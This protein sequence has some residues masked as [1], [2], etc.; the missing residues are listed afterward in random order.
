MPDWVRVLLAL[1][2]RVAGLVGLKTA[3]SKQQVE[4]EIINFNG[5]P[6]EK[7]ALFQVLA[8]NPQEI[9]TGQDDKH[10]NFRLS[11]RLENLSP[12][13]YRLWLI[14]TVVQH[15]QVGRW[16]M[17]VVKTVHKLI[18]TTILKNMTSRLETNPAPDPVS[19]Y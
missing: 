8:S 11:F 14:T 16:Y 2:E 1:R 17:A 9:V 18:V 6:G 13:E 12:G 4:Q 7:I 19:M 15:N 3:Q 5:Q 10:L